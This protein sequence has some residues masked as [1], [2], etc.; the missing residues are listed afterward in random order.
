MQATSGSWPSVCLLRGLFVLNTYRTWNLLTQCR[1]F[2]C[3]RE[4][5]LFLSN[6][7]TSKSSSTATLNWWLW[8]SN[9]GNIIMIQNSVYLAR[10]TT[11]G[12][13]KGENECTKM[14]CFV[15][16]NVKPSCYIQQHLYASPV[17]SWPTHQSLIELSALMTLSGSKKLSLSSLSESSGNFL[18]PELVAYSGN[19]GCKLE[20][21]FSTQFYY[22]VQP[23]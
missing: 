21:D 3:T 20:W 14:K 5:C 2:R 18:C 1:L 16:A 12:S 8:T 17:V 11:T 15:G 4:E 6:V 9:S 13:G 10:I 7:A 22:V 19:V 23:T